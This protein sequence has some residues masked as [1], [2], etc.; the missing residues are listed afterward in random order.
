MGLTQTTLSAAITANQTLI[1]VTSTATG[2]PAVGTVAANQPMRIDSEY[3]FI[4]GVP[5]AGMVT[6]RGRGSESTFAV[7]HDVLAVVQTSSAPADFPTPASAV[8]A[9]N[10][11]AVD[12]TATI[13]QD[14]A[15]A[16]P[17]V[18]TTYYLT[19]ATAAAVTI[20]S[21]LPTQQGVVLTFIAKT[22]MAH[23]ITYLPGFNADT[24]GSDVAT[25]NA[26]VGA[27]IVIEVLNDGTLAATS[28]QGVTLA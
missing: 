7:A 3:M 15:L 27:V 6:V 13:G 11:P 14:V 10:E 26:K 25:F 9:G 5:A 19:K 28:L 24:T 22:A 2:F 1:P 21:G 8:Q 20:A 16:I 12:A 18:S 4:T 23:T 17:N